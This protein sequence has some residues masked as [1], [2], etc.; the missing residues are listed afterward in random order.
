MVNSNE[1]TSDQYTDRRHVLSAVSKR[2]SCQNNPISVK[3]RDNK[4]KERRLTLEGRVGA[5]TGGVYASRK[6]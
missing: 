6:T 3:T 4:E 2:T 5:D 1:G